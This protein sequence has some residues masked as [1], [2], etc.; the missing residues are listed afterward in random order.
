ML[1]VTK[2]IML[3]ECLNRIAF[4]DELACKSRPGEPDDVTRSVQPGRERYLQPKSWSI[5]PSNVEGPVSRSVHRRRGEATGTRSAFRRR[6][7]RRRVPGCSTG[8]TRP[9]GRRTPRPG[10]TSAKSTRRTARTGRRWTA[11]PSEPL[12]GTVYRRRLGAPVGA[13]H[14]IDAPRSAAVG[15]PYLLS[16]LLHSLRC[17]CS[18]RHLGIYLFVKTGQ[19]CPVDTFPGNSV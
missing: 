7:R 4:K 2:C 5:L 1:R 8:P 18:V 19:S 9:S 15:L 13:P 3:V 14:V 12:L 16:G 11:P 17:T 10:P 6:S